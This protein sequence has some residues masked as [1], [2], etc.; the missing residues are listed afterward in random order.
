M[1]DQCIYISEPGQAVCCPECGLA[2][3]LIGPVL[4]GDLICDECEHS[5]LIALGI[6]EEAAA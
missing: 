2:V 1:T 6:P 5:I 3:H 4:D